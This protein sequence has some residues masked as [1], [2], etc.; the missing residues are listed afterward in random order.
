MPSFIVIHRTVW[1]QYSNVT[2]R[3]G[4]TE[5]TDRQR[6]DRLGLSVLQTVA[7]NGIFRAMVTTE[8]Q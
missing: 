6:S 3:T 7:Q 8:H 5:Q 1:P 2:D 4:H